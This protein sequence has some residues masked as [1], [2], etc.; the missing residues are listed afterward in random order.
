MT[1]INDSETTIVTSNNELLPSFA[2]LIPDEEIVSTLGAQGISSPTPVQAKVIPAALGGRDIIAQA[3]TGSGKTLSFV[4]PFV[5]KMQQIPPSR[6]T[7]GIIITPTRELALQVCAVVESLNSGLS[8]AAIIGGASA[9]K[10]IEMLKRDPRLVVGTPGRLLDLIEQREINL[11][12][13]EYF[14]LDEADEMLSL[15]FIEE[16]TTILSKLPVEKQGLF[17]SAT[18]SPRVS[19]LARRFLRNPTTITVET[20]SSSAPDIEH[21]Y[22]EVDSSLTAKVKALAS[23]LDARNPRSAI[24]F[25]NTK[26]DTEFIEVFLRRRGY[27]A[28]RINSDLPQ[29]ERDRIMGLVR[30]GNLK[31]LIATDVA[32]RGIDISQIDLVINYSIHDQTETYVHRTGRTGR[33]GRSGCAIS[34]IGPQDGSAFHLLKKAIDFPINEYM[35]PTESEIATARLAQFES[36]IATETTTPSLAHRELAKLFL[37]ERA[38]V[39]QPSD[40]LIDLLARLMGC[41]DAPKGTDENEPLPVNNQPAKRSALRNPD[42]PSGGRRRSGQRRSRSRD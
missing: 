19:M 41:L 36:K 18:I 15:G 31:V 34:I 35:I 25:C 22:C 29:K 26:S 27:D 21:L 3:Q 32:A 33:A 13:C 6:S 16:V 40:E 5:L 37:S 1:N 9:H 10:Q 38:Q 30:S 7:L 2:E 28:L 20:D 24:V 39:A 17:L 8:P 12:R 42:E 14:V 11:R 4:L 23:I